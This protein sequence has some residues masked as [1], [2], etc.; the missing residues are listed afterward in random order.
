MLD[1]SL[2]ESMIWA[3]GYRGDGFEESCHTGKGKCTFGK[4]RSKVSES[5]YRVWRA[6]R[7]Q[8]M[9]SLRVEPWAKI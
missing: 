1:N 6:S 5:E 3:W 8:V 4:E 7:W 9:R 2:K